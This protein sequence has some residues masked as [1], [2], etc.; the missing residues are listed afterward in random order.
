MKSL[1][2]WREEASFSPVFA[3]CGFS[4]SFSFVRIKSNRRLGTRV[5]TEA[6]IALQAQ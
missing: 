6:K 4:V 5:D 1:L 2:C 3:F